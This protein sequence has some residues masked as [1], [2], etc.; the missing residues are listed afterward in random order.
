MTFRSLGLGLALATALT[1]P[2][3]AAGVS[4]A[5][6][7]T[8]DLTDWTFTAGF[9]DV[10]M[11]ADDAVVAPPF[12][13]HFVATEGA[14]FAHLTAGSDDTDFAVYTMLSQ[15]FEVTEASRLTG[16]AAFLAFDSLPYNDDAF[17][18]IF[19]GTS[20][21][22][23]FASNIKK[24]DDYGHTPWTPFASG[25]LGPGFYILEAGVR[26]GLDF[27]NSSQ[28]L[29]DNIQITAVAVPEPAA[30][31]LLIAGFAT[32]GAALRRRRP[33]ALKT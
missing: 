29:L 4:N 14:Y 21:H 16:D 15:M 8:G 1:V 13:E 23:L 22:L 9:V 32:A 20:R 3:Y 25:R 6:F 12:G 7:E 10:L 26:D 30:W 31:A 27:G 2:A 33:L 28:L 18:R 17:V 19:D 11:E 5:G 24:V